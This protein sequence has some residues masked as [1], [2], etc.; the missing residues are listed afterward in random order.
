MSG[1]SVT[2]I[3]QNISYTPLTPRDSAKFI[4]KFSKNVSINEEGVKNVTRLVHYS[5]LIFTL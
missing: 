5:L 2:N 3:Q 4:S 1:R